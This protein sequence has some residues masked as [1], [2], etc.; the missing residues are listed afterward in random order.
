MWIYSILD[1]EIPVNSYIISEYTWHIYRYFLSTLLHYSTLVFTCTHLLVFSAGAMAEKD[2]GILICVQ[3][4]SPWLF[5]NFS[6]CFLKTFEMY[7]RW[8]SSESLTMHSWNLARNWISVSTSWLEEGGPLHPCHWDSRKSRSNSQKCTAT[9]ST[10]KGVMISNIKLFSQ[11]LFI[12]FSN[13]E[14]L[15]LPGYTCSLTISGC[16]S[17]GIFSSQLFTNRRNPAA[18]GTAFPS[19]EHVVRRDL[20]VFSPWHCGWRVNGAAGVDGWMGGRLKG[21]K[22]P[23]F[24]I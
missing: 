12:L 10:K 9:S 19:P 6:D 18:P 16:F 15:F 11:F 17:T 13:T 5:L 23:P 8:N 20:L 7:L 4:K 22:S 24:F 3:N 14:T 1:R 2:L 21:V